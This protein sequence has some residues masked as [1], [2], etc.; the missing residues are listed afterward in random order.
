MQHGKRANDKARKIGRVK[1][2][3][4]VVFQIITGTALDSGLCCADP[5]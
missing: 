1:K 4:A 2:D 5:E 3:G